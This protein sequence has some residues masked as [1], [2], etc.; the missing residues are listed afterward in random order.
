MRNNNAKT[1][2]LGGMLG[3]VAVVI[4]CLGGMIPLATYV[5]P[6]LC[7]LMG[8]LVLKLCGRRIAWAWY[9]AVA[10]LGLL[11]CPDKEAA[12]VYLLLGYYPN[13]KPW[14]DRRKLP[15][16]WKAIIFNSAI[17]LLYGALIHVLGLG[18]VTEEFSELGNIGLAVLLVLGNLTFFLLDRLLSR[19]GKR[20]K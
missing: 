10:L 12:A 11:M 3:A 1:I 15:W 18:A 16:L 20:R 13:L 5:I 19:M 2:A 8:H 14:I 9:G 4:M 17:C 6:V 7:C